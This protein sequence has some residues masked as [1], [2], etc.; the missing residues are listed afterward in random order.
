MSNAATIHEAIKKEIAPGADKALKEYKEVSAKLGETVAKLNAALAASEERAV[1]LEL[2]LLTVETGRVADLMTRTGALLDKL[3]ALE[4]DDAVVDDAAEVEQ[5]SKA[6]DKLKTDLSS[7]FSVGKKLEETANGFLEKH[8]D[9]EREVMEKRAVLEAWAKKRIEEG[10]ERF[11]QMEKVHAELTSALQ[12]RDEEALSK[13]IKAS[14]EIRDWAGQ[15]LDKEVSGKVEEFR[16][17]FAKLKPHTVSRELQEQMARDDAKITA[18]A[19]HWDVKIVEIHAHQKDSKIKPLDYRKAAAVL[20]IP[21]THE[22]KLKKALD[23][24]RS[25]MVKALDQLAR[26]LHQR[27]GGK[28]MMALLDKEHLL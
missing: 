1:R 16:T 6:L 3:E 9:G 21:A 11:K 18:D 13:A 20:K 25:V 10:S 8:V 14:F 28:D 27:A 4:S 17:Y 5:F 23:S 2:R 24:K 7:E 22:A 12:E 15:A 26:E 19:F